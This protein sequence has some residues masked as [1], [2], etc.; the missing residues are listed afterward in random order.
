MSTQSYA[1]DPGMSRFTVRAFASGFL[2]AMGHNP[3]FAIRDFS[4]EAK[5]SPENVDQSALRLQINPKSL[6]VTDNISDKDRR[7]IE[8]TADQNVLETDRFP[9]IVFESSKVTASQ[10]GNGQYLLNLAGELTL[11]GTRKPQAV[12]AQVALLGD[13]LRAHGE[14][15][16][17]QTA[18]GIKPVSIAGGS[19]KL[20]DEVKLTFDILARKR[21]DGE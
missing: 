5:F 12:S 8:R 1:I 19:L 6:S 18:F 2:S 17:Q 13:T 3:T 7:E 10:S 21:K 11:H 16:V 4:G 14:F 9:E 15:S 20:K